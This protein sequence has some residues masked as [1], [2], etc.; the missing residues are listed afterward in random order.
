MDEINEACSIETDEELD[1][2]DFEDET[3]VDNLVAE[4]PHIIS[5]LIKENVECSSADT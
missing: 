2:N 1:S 3:P 4:P 5:N